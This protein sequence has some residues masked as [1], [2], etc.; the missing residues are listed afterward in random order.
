MEDQFPSEWSEILS[1][2]GRID[3]LHQELRG[4]LEKLPAHVKGAIT[5]SVISMGPYVYLELKKR[6]ERGADETPE[7][8]FMEMSKALDDGS[9]EMP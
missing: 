6:K 9:G 8:I 2:Y 1:V 3:A 5:G 4:V 7:G